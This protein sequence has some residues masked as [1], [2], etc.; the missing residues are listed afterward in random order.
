[1]AL[2]SSPTP[3]SCHSWG[4][5]ALPHLPMSFICLSE[6]VYS[7]LNRLPGVTASYTH[8]YLILLKS[9]EGMSLASSYAAA[10]LDLQML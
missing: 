6:A 9:N 10:I 2:T 8:V 7:V 3:E 1:M 4:S 5:E